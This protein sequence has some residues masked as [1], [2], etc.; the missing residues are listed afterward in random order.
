MRLALANGY[1]SSILGRVCVWTVIVYSFVRI[2]YIF[3]IERN[4]SPTFFDE[5]VCVILAYFA[6]TAYPRTRFLSK[7]MAILIPFLLYLII[8]LMGFF[9]YGR[10]FGVHGQQ[11]IVGVLLDAKFLL[12][13][14]GFVAMFAAS[15]VTGRDLRLFLKGLVFVSILNFA[16]VMHDL[17]VTHDIYGA[18][19]MTRDGMRIPNGLFGHKTPSG[20][21]HLIAYTAALSLTLQKSTR[22]Y[23]AA[24]FLNLLAIFIHQG[25]KEIIAA[26]FVSLI[27]LYQYRYIRLPILMT[28]LPAISFLSLLLLVGDNLAPD[29]GFINRIQYYVSSDGAESARRVLWSAA[30]EIAKDHAPIGTGAGS[31][32][33]EPS[34]GVNFSK[35]YIRYGVGGYGLSEDYSMYLLDNY[36]AKILGEGGFLGLFAMISFI[37]AILFRAFKVLKNLKNR[38]TSATTASADNFGVSIVVAAIACSAGSS[39][40]SSEVMMVPLAFGMGYIIWRGRA[41]PRTASKERLI[42]R[43]ITQQRDS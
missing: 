24:A 36:W 34:R 28:I 7:M 10:G 22:L 12:V 23:L 5:L 11:A 15:V 25:S 31:F 2:S 6:V 21:M 35:V 1:N 40:F 9:V 8:S 43:T 4:F 30:S 38:K 29:I 18:R 33:S 16:F 37:S 26:L 13:L 32:A 39:V 17:L 3:L 27:Y 42:G 14:I 20:Q 41:Q 19:L